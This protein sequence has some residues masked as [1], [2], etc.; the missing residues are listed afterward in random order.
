MERSR[1]R[2][3]TTQMVSR[4]RA[5]DAKP[6]K[7]YDGDFGKVL[8]TGSTLL[9]LAVSGGR[10]R[11]GGLPGG[12][13]IEAFGPNGSGKTVLLTEIAG[14]VQRKG[15]DVIFQ[16]PEA[17]LNKQFAQ[18]FGLKLKKEAYK[19][20]D[21]VVQVFNQVTEWEPEPTV[22]GAIN[23]I[24]TDSLAALST[25][26]ELD[27]KQGDK[28]GMKR[29]KDF[30]E[31]L[32]K[33]CRILAKKNYIMVCS[34]QVRQNSESAG[35]PY[36][37]KYSTPGGLAVGFYASVRL[38]FSKPEKIK[39][40]VTHKGKEITRVVGVTSTVEV[41]KNSVWS[42][43]RTAPLHIL[44]DYGIDDIRANLQYVKD[45]TGGKTYCVNNTSLSKSLDEAITL[46]EEK[47]LVN[48]LKEQVI[49]LWEAIES[50]FKKERAPKQ[51]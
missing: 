5:N 51:R 35:N 17:R 9:N 43:Y 6:K 4:V 49:D 32:R 15:G 27:S 45:M 37:E 46:C 21:T 38:K 39:E 19:R 44:F 26:L 36:A 20:P 22:K 28:M 41:Y 18:M 50:K 7:I 23:G 48:D 40:K 16:D 34:N 3:L 29:G 10:I 12:I 13:L 24:F 30:S 33:F 42:P 11:G 14:E 47:G 2:S 8:S 1:T 31:Q 25:E